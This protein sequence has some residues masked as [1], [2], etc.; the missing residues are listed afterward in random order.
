MD[1]TGYFFRALPNRSLAMKK[2]DCKG[3]K[4]AKDRITVA[5][6][7]SALGEKLPPIVIGK[8]QKPRCLRGVALEKVVYRNCPKA[9]MVNP[10]FH[11]YHLNLNKKML[12]SGM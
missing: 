10:I 11:E 9:W 3:G 6:T 5:L 2:V 12:I 4:L 1:E 8:S 7:C